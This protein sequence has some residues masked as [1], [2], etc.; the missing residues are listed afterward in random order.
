MCHGAGYQAAMERR[1]GGVGAYVCLQVRQVSQHNDVVRL[2]AQRVPVA[3]D[4]FRVVPG[5]R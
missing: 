3:L 5:G 4:G 2:D 1:G